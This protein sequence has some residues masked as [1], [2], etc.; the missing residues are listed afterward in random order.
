LRGRDWK[1]FHGHVGENLG[2]SLAR[3]TD[4]FAA[5]A[6]VQLWQQVEDCGLY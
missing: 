1:I 2:E 4:H 6:G 5:A 3:E